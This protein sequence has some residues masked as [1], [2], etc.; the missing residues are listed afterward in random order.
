MQFRCKERNLSAFGGSFPFWE[1]THEDLSPLGVGDND[2][3]ITKGQGLR[4]YSGLSKNQKVGVQV[5]LLL[6][7]VGFLRDLPRKK[8]SQG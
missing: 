8:V 4:K 3:L 1:M 7:G 6:F 2:Q 5:Q